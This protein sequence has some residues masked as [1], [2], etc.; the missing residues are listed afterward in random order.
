MEFSVDALEYVLEYNK[1]ISD[2]RKEIR[3]SLETN[4]FASDSRKQNCWDEL[5]KI[6]KESED[7]IIQFLSKLQREL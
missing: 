1:V 4:F 7:E 2:L 5:Q 6:P 3:Q